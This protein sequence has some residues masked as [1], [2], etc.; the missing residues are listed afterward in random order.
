VK[1][2]SKK[3]KSSIEKTTLGDITGLAALKEEMEE[4][5]KKAQKEGK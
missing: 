1:K 4:K 3:L 5:Q 2:A